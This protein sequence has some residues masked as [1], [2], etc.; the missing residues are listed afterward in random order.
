MRTDDR[1]RLLEAKCRV[2]EAMLISLIAKADID[3]DA[4]DVADHMRGSARRYID[5]YRKE[6]LLEAS[7]AEDFLSELRALRL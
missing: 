7:V 2:L 4:R 5:A 6:G 1:V 3:S